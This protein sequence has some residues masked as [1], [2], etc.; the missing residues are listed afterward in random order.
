MRRLYGCF[1]HTY[2][3]EEKTL[4]NFYIETTVMRFRITA[5]WSASRHI[6]VNVC[7]FE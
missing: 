6:E 4:D 3:V 5:P 2:L 1:W 7:F